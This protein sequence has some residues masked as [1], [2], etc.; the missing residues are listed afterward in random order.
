MYVWLFDIDGTLIRSG[1][2]GQRSMEM[3]LKSV[4]GVVASLD[5]IPFAGRTDYAITTDVLAACHLDDTPFNREEF[6][7]EYLRL[8]AQNLK[9]C[10]GT[11]LPGVVDLLEFLNEAANVKLGLLTG[12][13]SG[14]AVLKLQH[15]GIDHFFEFGGYGNHDADRNS[16]AERA[17]SAAC[18]SVGRKIER[19]RIWVVGDT[20]NDINCGKSIGANTIA[21]ATGSFAADEMKPFQPNFLCSDLSK[22]DRNDL[23]MN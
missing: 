3:T 1:G 22:L 20:P 13:I 4:F 7:D 9:T 21:V 11:I 5:G 6:Q 18:Q 17:Y 19:D 2:V 14:A 10:V 15:F 16:V 12:N 23:S 8:L